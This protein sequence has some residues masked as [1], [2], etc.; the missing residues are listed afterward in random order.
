VLTPKWDQR[1]ESGFLQR[2]VS[3]EPCGCRGRRNAGGTQSSNPLPPSAESCA[4]PTSSERGPAGP[5]FC[6][7]VRAT[8][9]PGLAFSPGFFP[10]YNEHERAKCRRRLSSGLARPKRRRIAWSTSRRLVPTAVIETAFPRYEGGV[11]PLYDIGQIGRGTG[12]RTRGRPVKSRL[13][14]H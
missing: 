14:C 1:F 10:R 6:L 12:N 3:C 9:R 4:N 7:R 2:G 13:L 8:L 11:L 5:H